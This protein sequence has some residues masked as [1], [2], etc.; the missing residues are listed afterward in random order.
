MKD[1]ENG[2]IKAILMTLIKDSKSLSEI[3][4]E[5][6]LQ[7]LRS[8]DDAIS[9]LMSI[10]ESIIQSPLETSYN[11]LLDELYGIGQEIYH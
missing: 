2:L 5:E 7:S 4:K 8:V 10:D 6:T 9:S 11:S 3:Q 1:Y